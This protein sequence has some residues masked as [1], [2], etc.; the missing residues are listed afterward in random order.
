[1]YWKKEAIFITE[2]Y[3]DIPG[4][5]GRYQVSN[6][7]NVKSLNYQNTHKAKVM[8]PIAH[9]RGYMIIHLGQE[10]IKFIHTLVAKAFIPNPEGKKYVNHIDGNKHNNIVTNLEW[11]TSK[12]NVNHAIRT[13]LRNPDHY[14]R[15]MG[16]E[17]ANARAIEQYTKDGQFVKRWDCI[18]DAARAFN[19][20]P[21][22]IINNASGRLLT[23][24]GYVWKY[25]D[26][27]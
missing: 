21:S 12:E 25:T 9:H 27:Q 23:A 5:E 17:R 2:I 7:G 8:T 4:Y 20:K 19:C 11:V 22:T 1:M 10:N 6:L 16:V 26:N 24:R 13:G 18:S 14:Y 3:K 15:A